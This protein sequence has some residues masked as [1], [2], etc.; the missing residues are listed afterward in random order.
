M[1]SQL[2]MVLALSMLAYSYRT[3]RAL[4]L[5]SVLTALLRAFQIHMHGY[6]PCAGII[7]YHVPDVSIPVGQSLGFAVQTAFGSEIVPGESSLW[8]TNPGEMPFLL[9]FGMGWEYSG[10]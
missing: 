10:L 6:Q 7:M 3:S 5:N 4:K 1:T 2:L 9:T 8:W